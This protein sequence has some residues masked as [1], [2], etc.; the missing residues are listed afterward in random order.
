L[1]RH[2]NDALSAR[3]R[4]VLDLEARGAEVLAVAADVTNVE[5][6]REVLSEAE[7]RFGAVHGVIHAAGVLRDQP[8][9]GKRQDDIDAVFSP[10]VYGTMVLLEALG[11]RPLDFVVLFSSTSVA[12]A[13]AGQVDYVAA[14]A[15]LNATAAR[16]R[17]GPLRC[18]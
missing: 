12:T 6:M 18:I 7:A 17:G 11:D 3:L 14:N 1:D 5:R 13:P 8:M 16:L 4:A 9:I 10:K 2:P 15:F